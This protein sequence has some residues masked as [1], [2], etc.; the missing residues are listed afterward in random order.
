MV[1]LP[2]TTVEEFCDV[3]FV[4]EKARRAVLDA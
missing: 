4:K 3:Y 1:A 2:L